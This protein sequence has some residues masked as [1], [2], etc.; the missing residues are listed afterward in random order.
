M[1]LSMVEAWEWAAARLA[2]RAAVGAR[3]YTGRF[4]GTAT[5]RRRPSRAAV[6]A[7]ADGLGSAGEG[8]GFSCRAARLDRRVKC[9]ASSIVR[10]LLRFARAPER[11]RQMRVHVRCKHGHLAGQSPV[12]PDS[13]ERAIAPENAP[14]KPQPF[15]ILL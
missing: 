1:Y 6:L 14:L 5:I 15:A 8:H 3:S 13:L 2:R 10:R 11:A 7:A 12:P 9:T 4:P